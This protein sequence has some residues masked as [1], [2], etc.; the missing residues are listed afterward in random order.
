V[1]RKSNAGTKDYD[2]PASHSAYE[3]D[4]AAEADEMHK[5]I[6]SNFNAFKVERED[7]A[8]MGHRSPTMFAKSLFSFRRRHRDRRGRRDTAYA[9][10]LDSLV[11]LQELVC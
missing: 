2:A 1:A 3:A 9:V 11:D 10:A 5:G 7:G 6:A 4:A 8:L